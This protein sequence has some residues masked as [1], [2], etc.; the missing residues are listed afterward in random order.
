MDI[1]KFYDITHREHVV[2]N[3]TSQR[4]LARLVELLRLPRGSR[5]VDI[6]CGKGEFLI[7]LAEAYD[8]R[9]TGIDISPHFVSA[10]E[11]RLEARVPGAKITLTRMDGADFRP[12]RPH[13]LSLAS[14][15]GASWIFGGHAGTLDALVNLAEP[16]G[17]VIA[18]EPFWLREPPEEYLQAAGLAKDAFGSHASN[19]EAGERRGLDLVYTIASSKDDWD[20]YEGLQW[21]ATAEHARAHPD[22]PDLPELVERVARNKAAYLRWG[23]DTV[24]WAIYVFRRGAG[25]GAGRAV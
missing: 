3:P 7:R 6:A 22:D 21:Y 17:W 10:A 4:A 13:S 8:V 24:G 2:C 20:N 19:A 14:C 16:G 9:G 5:V 11:A 1:W 25:A 12:D 15:I 18:G 23:R